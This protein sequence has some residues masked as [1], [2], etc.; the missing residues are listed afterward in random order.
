MSRQHQVIAFVI[1]LF[2]LAI[3]SQAKIKTPYVFAPKEK[4]SDYD[5]FKGNI[6]EQNPQEDVIPYQLNTPLFSDYAEKLRFVRLPIGAKATYQPEEVIDFPV[7]TVIIKTFYYPKDFRN[8]LKGRQIVE[9]RLLVKEENTW[10]AWTYIWNDTQTDA[11]LEVA[12]ETKEISWIHTDGKK[13][14][15]QYSI[16]NINQCKGCHN[17]DEKMTPIGLSIRQLNGTFEYTNEGTMNQL[18][19]WQKHQLISQLPTDSTTWGKIPIWNDPNTGSIDQR[20]RAWL[21][22]NCAHCHHPQGPARTSGLF[23]SYNEKDP[24]KFGVFKT[25][26]A[27]GRGSGGLQY[28]IVPAKPEESILY[29]RINSTDP[30]VM[31]PELGRTIVHQEGALLIKNWIK[32]LQP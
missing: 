2:C 31:M 7:G 14:T 10:S 11:F 29:Y 3:F 6:A 4:L 1:A 12:G 21:E 24:I 27:A 17:R 23:L 18:V 15:I 22:I 20:A 32:S 30:G 28:S 9:T 26:V 25:P 8:P 13:K 19:Y 16:P 5:F